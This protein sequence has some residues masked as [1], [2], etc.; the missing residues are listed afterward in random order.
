LLEAIR[1]YVERKRANG[2]LYVTHERRLIYF[3]RRVGDVPLGQISVRHVLTF[4]DGPKTSAVAWQKKHELLR[5]FFDFW[6]ARGSIKVSPLPPKRKAAARTSIPY[7]YT[8]A[9][10]RTLPQ[11]ARNC[12]KGRRCIDALTVSTLFIFLYGTGCF[13]GEA[14]RVSVKDI[15]LKRGTISIRN[16][17]LDIVRELPIGPDLKG[18]LGRY[19][20]ARRRVATSDDHLFLDKYGDGLK[21]PTLHTT[22]QRIRRSSGIVRLDGAFYQ[23]RMQDLRHTFAVHRITSWIKH[24]ADLKRM[25]PALAAYM[26]QSGLGSTERYLAL[27]AERFRTQ[28]SQLSTSRVGKRWRDDVA[29]MKFLDEL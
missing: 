27:T 29:L 22:F 20:I 28:L 21:R 13:P 25:L 6:L 17:R 18:V 1:V 5:A 19:L 15:D 3:S 26:G 4:L 23:P 24:G 8:H 12:Q 14:I 2:H 7:I 9:E 10:I 11:A 16:G